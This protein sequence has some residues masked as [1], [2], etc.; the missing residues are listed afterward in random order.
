MERAQIDEKTGIEADDPEAGPVA[1]SQ[2]AFLTLLYSKYR[3]A[4]FRYVHAIVSSRDEAEDVVQETY[5]RVVRQA[6]VARFEKSARNYLFATAANVAR[7]HLRKRR[8]RSHEPFDELSEGHP[9]AADGQPESALALNETLD[10]LRAGINSLPGLTRD[11]FIMSRM[12]DKT[13]AEIAE[14]LGVSVRTVDRK[15]SDALARLASRL[16]GNL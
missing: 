14:A 12:R 10:A 11:I 5:F 7:D 16:Q 4:L 1:Q 9:A 6:Q 15:L 8:F 13:H 2:L 3:A